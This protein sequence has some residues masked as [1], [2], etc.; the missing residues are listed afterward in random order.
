M[1]VKRLSILYLKTIYNILLVGVL[2]GLLFFGYYFAYQTFSNDPYDSIDVKTEPITITSK[3]SVEKVAREL[4][5]KELII[6]RY[7]FQMRK[8]FSKY[9]TQ[10]FVPGTYWISSSLGIEDI[11]AILTGERKQVDERNQ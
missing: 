8:S 7:Q 5:K 11:I 2:F 4:R 1:R 3:D 9:R 10:K 6:G